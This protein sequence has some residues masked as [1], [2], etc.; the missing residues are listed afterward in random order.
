[1][2]AA[3]R[4]DAIV[5]L[6]PLAVAG[7]AHISRR[8]S[9]K[10]IVEVGKAAR[11]RRELTIIDAVRANAREHDA[12]LQSRQCELEVGV[13][14]CTLVLEPLAVVAANRRLFSLFAMERE[15]MHHVTL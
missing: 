6:A 1:M 10:S 2:A 14:Q 8:Q 4:F 3:L 13:E 7:P 9:T 11:G 12:A 15:E 5:A